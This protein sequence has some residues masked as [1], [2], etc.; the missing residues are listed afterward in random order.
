M[1]FEVA[2]NVVAEAV[3]RIHPHVLI[4]KREGLLTLPRLSRADLYRKGPVF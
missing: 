1:G 3:P 4:N 2:L